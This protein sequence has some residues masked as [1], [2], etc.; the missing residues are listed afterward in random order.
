MTTPKEAFALADA[1]NEFMLKHETHCVLSHAMMSQLRLAL[2]EV[3]SDT[4]RFR[5]AWRELW[6]KARSVVDAFEYP[7]LKEGYERQRS[8]ARVE[9][10][11]AL[12]EE[13]DHTD[14]VASFIRQVFANSPEPPPFFEET[15]QDLEPMRVAVPQ[16]EV[17]AIA[18]M[19]K[20]RLLGEEKT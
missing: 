14:P 8:N 2:M 18:E 3:A 13:L 7:P 12:R 5:Q 9:S 20:K 19:V 16:E 4:E 1:A 11:R 15:L 10:L 17:D 6:E